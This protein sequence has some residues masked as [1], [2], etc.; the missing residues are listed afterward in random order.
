MDSVLEFIFFSS[1]LA[2]FGI[3]ISNWEPRQSVNQHF[4]VN[5]KQP[6]SVSALAPVG[7]TR[8]H[9]FEVLG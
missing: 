6:A 7:L 2:L 4:N 1:L 9:V 5:T 3:L 8:F